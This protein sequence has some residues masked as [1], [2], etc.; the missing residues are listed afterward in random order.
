[1]VNLVLVR[2]AEA[3]PVGPGVTD[4]DRPLTSSGEKA[5]A[6]TGRC[7]AGLDLTKPRILCSPKLRALQTARIVAAEMRAAEP[8]VAECLSGGYDPDAILSDL[9]EHGR[10]G[11]LI[12]VGHE[13]DM[14]R[15]LARLLDPVWGGTI[16]F[17]AGGHAWVEVGAVPPARAGRLRGFGDPT[18][19]V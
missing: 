4:G 18:G 8:I 17:P 1:M 10:D 3:A 11:A 15:L 2:H 19:V 6:A 9:A 16:P 7:L 5:A 13:P 14:G 12:L